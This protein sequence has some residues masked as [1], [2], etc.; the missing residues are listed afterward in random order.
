MYYTHPDWFLFDAAG[1]RQPLNQ[2][3]VGLNPC[4]REVRDHI[5]DLVH[6][7]LANY[8]IDGI[9]LD[10]IRYVWDEHPAQAKKLFPRDGQTLA[11]YR[12]DTGPEPG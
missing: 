9:H 10:Y 8:D 7:L 3:Y 11:L 4:R 12:R 6:E 5:T 2:E 1:R